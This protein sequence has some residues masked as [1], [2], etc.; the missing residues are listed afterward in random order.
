MFL[1]TLMQTSIERE[2][3]MHACLKTLLAKLYLVLV[4]CFS[5]VPGLSI[6]RSNYCIGLT[7]T[8]T[9]RPQIAFFK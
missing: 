8:L 4:Y 9:A 6:T 1:P 5:V 2:E 3:I 7:G